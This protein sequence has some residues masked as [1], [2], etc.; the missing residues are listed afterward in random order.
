MSEKAKEVK[1]ILQ[2]HIKS[3]PELTQDQALSLLIQAVKLAT[4]R[5]AYEIEETELILK[6]IRVFTPKQ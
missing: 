2:S 5:G 1:E 6:A 4:K 3:D